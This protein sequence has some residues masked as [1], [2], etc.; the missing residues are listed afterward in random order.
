MDGVLT[1]RPLLRLGRRTDNRQA[2]PRFA[3]SPKAR[4]RS[5]DLRH[6]SRVFIVNTRR[7]LI[8]GVTPLV[9]Q[10]ALKKKHKIIQ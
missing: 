8:Q 7:G 10:M 2:R 6:D 3:R 4:G 9:R 5:L 1:Q